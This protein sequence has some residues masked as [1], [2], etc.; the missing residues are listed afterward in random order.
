M[1]SVPAGTD[2]ATMRMTIARASPRRIATTVLMLCLAQPACAGALV[3]IGGTGMAL[4][5]LREVGASL[6]AAEPGI[7][8]EVLPSMGTSGGIKA[9]LEGAIEIAVAARP[10]TAAEKSKG[11]G[12]V[13]CVTTAVVFATSHKAA[14]GMTTAGLPGIYADPA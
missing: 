1:L 10:L 5:A 14:S 4:E 2:P 6:A 9:V 7:Q 11:F 12:E 8:V 13:A 3:R